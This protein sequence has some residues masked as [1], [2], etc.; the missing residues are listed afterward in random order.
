MRRSPSVVSFLALIGGWLAIFTPAVLSLSLRMME[1]DSENFL[2]TY[3]VALAAGWLTLIA[4][5]VFFGALGDRLAQRRGSRALIARW[6]V[7]LLIIAGVLLAAA[8][9]NQWVIAAWLFLQ[10]PAAM[11]I[12]TAL[13]VGGGSATRQQRGV[14]SGLVGASS[15]VAL[16]VG[17]LV[18]AIL[19]DNV[20][21]G[22][23]VSTLLGAGLAIPLMFIKERPAPPLLQSESSPLDHRGQK[24]MV[25]WIVFLVSSFLLSWTTSTANAFIVALIENLSTIDVADVATQ[26]SIAVALASIAT[27]ISS[28]LSGIV[29]RSPRL[30]AIHWITGTLV[31]AASIFFLAFM[32]QGAA[33][34]IAAIA[35]GIGFG[36]ANGVEVTLALFLRPSGRAV[37]KNLSLLTSITTV[38]YVLV[39]AVAAF[40][41]TNDTS[42]GLQYLFMVAVITAAIGAALLTL[43]FLAIRQPNEEL[44][45]TLG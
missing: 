37:G 20:G 43:A 8:P 24:M 32:P 7:A 18:I 12:S 40:A 33:L 3:P 34:F 35:F 4:S 19:A 13:A 14:V 23:L 17:S 2:D 26:A 31:T 5:L 44:H 9:T 15:I 28:I 29:A 38:P 22:I 39:P 16:L 36:A 41:L 11:V 1:F 45:H 21:A 42:A 10:I 25:L 30:A 27:V 6:G